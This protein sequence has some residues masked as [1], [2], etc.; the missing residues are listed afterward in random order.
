MMLSNCQTDL[1]KKCEYGLDY[2]SIP[3]E[4]QEDL[5]WLAQHGYCGTLHGM[6]DTVYRLTPKGRAYLADLENQAEKESQEMIRKA[7]ER[8]KEHTHDYR[9]AVFS[10]LLTFFLGLLS[11]VLL[12]HFADI[13]NLVELAFKIKLP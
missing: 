9:V 7:A 2:Y 13:V 10:S 1:L 12:E 8:T 6:A 11:G 5:M 3:E 4:A